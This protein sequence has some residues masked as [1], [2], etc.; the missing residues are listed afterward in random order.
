M[1]FVI[2]TIVII[3]LILIFSY[4]SPDSYI[5]DGDVVFKT[6]F[7]SGGSL[8]V[9]DRLIFKPKK[10]VLV[11]KSGDLFTTT[12]VQTIP[13][14]NIFGVKETQFIIGCNILIIGS[15]F[16][17]ISLVGFTKKDGKDIMKSIN[18]ILEKK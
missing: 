17:N 6:S 9:P 14:K 12:T 5:D 4:E 3:F 16:Q 13:Y 8:M 15:G 11:S 18:L 1:I 7:T 2:I 10:V